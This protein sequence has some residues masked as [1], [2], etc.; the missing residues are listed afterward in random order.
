M[1][2]FDFVN[3]FLIDKGVTRCAK[4]KV[5]L[6]NKLNYAV[7]QMPLGC[8]LH[9]SPRHCGVCAI[10]LIPRAL[11]RLVFELISKPYSGWGGLKFGN[12]FDGF[13]NITMYVMIG[14]FS[15]PYFE[16]AGYT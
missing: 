9:C 7:K 8:A 1:M 10:H 12:F 13:E 4:R 11:W 5:W 3:Q 2:A 15:K 6:R 14:F 16:M